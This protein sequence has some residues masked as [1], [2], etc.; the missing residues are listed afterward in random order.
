M[1]DPISA[2]IAREVSGWPSAGGCLDGARRIGARLTAAVLLILCGSNLGRA[3]DVHPYVGGAAEISTWGVHSW[4]GAPS[5]T[6]NNTSAD[7]TVVGV[8][9][10]AGWFLGRR[11]AVG[12]E[13][14]IPLGRTTVA[15]QYGYFNPYNRLSQYRETEL[16]GVFHGYVPLSRRVQLGILGGGGFVFGSSIDQQSNC[17]FDPS[18]PCAPFSAPKESTR[19]SLGATV[20]GDLAVQAAHG[21][22]VVSQFRMVWVSRG[23][24]PVSAG[25][26]LGFVGLGI[27][28]V[29]Y[30]AS[31]GLRARF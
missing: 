12:A 24:D 23:G 8:V 31:I 4:S 2:Q 15:S 1:D 13:F 11:I 21:L 18:I 28:S 26:N 17:N 9:G 20:G 14:D 30:R 3:Q 10:E 29:S 6:Y 16:F 19:T 7:T 22:A 25:Q 5:I 27:D